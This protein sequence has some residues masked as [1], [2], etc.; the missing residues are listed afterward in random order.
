MKVLRMALM[1]IGALSVVRFILDFVRNLDENQ[2]F[3][4][5]RD[6]ASSTA[7]DV[8]VGM[9][10][11]LSS[12]QGGIG[13]LIDQLNSNGLYVLGGALFALFLIL[14]A[15]RSRSSGGGGGHDD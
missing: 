13:S 4:Q 10:S 14:R 12:I 2:Q 5:A 6:Y 1:G 3:I 11:G 15:T 7:Q 9:N 8:Q